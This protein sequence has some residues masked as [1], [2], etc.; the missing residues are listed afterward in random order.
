MFMRGEE[1]LSGAQRIHD[2]DLL[3][4]RSKEHGIGKLHKVNESHFLSNCFVIE[5]TQDLDIPF[6]YIHVC[7]PCF[8]G[9]HWK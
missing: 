2:P 1:I 4:E 3:T 9:N 6:N 5:L 8:H 7:L